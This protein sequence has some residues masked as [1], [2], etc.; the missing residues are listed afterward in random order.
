MEDLGLTAKLFE[1]S[2]KLHLASSWL[3]KVAKGFEP[4]T[5]GKEAL[6]WAGRF[7]SEV[8]W[9]S[10]TEKRGLAGFALQATTVRPTFYSSLFRI[11]PQLREAGMK[12]EKDILGFLSQLYS[13]LYYSDNAEKDHKKLNAIQSRIGALLLQ[14]ISRSLRVQLNNNGLP[15]K[16]TSLREDWEPSAN[17]YT[18]LYLAV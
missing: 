9:S 11:A 10:R 17:E 3:E 4:D 14:E 7:L 2:S 6:S 13:Y 18:P 16:T 15:R 12:S 5:S 8:D 1:T